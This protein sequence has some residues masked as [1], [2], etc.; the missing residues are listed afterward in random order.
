MY[1]FSGGLSLEKWTDPQ[2]C[3]KNKNL[4]WA[5]NGQRNTCRGDTT[6]TLHN[7]SS[8]FLLPTNTSKYRLSDVRAKTRCIPSQEAMTSF[9]KMSRI[10][11]IH[12]NWAN[13]ALRELR[14]QHSSNPMGSMPTPP[15]N[16]LSRECEIRQAYP[17]FQRC[18]CPLQ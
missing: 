5:R 1:T 12:R 4:E 3:P 17:R 9:L 18:S 10:M 8:Y 14:S 15:K 16:V 13:K 11:S 7:C 6:T 2:E